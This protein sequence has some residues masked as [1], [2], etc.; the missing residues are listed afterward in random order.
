MWKSQDSIRRD[1]LYLVCGANGL[2]GSITLFGRADGPAHEF[3]RHIM[4]TPVWASLLV[5]ATTA[6]LCGFN[7]TGAA[8]GSVTWGGLTGAS[9]LAV[10]SRTA[11]WDAGWVPTGFL[12]A[13]HL[14]IYQE[15]SSGRD[16]DRE[17]RQRGG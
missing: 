4:P 3:L 14:V 6:I 1:W 8:L 5:T 12:F 16:A 7:L 15:V 17:W 13:C 9:L 2:A 10:A 11:L